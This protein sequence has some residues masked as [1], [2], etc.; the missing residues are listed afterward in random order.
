VL[1]LCKHTRPNSNHAF[2]G[3][4]GHR[5]GGN[6]LRRY[7]HNT[8]WRIAVKKTL[9]IIAFSLTL[10]ASLSSTTA[11]ACSRF[12]INNY[13]CSNGQVVGCTL[14]GTYDG[15]GCIYACPAC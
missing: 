2:H 13:S 14:I 3:P 8:F 6:D 5:P 10:A 7:I 1:S 9:R 11:F 4:F 15:G 12:W